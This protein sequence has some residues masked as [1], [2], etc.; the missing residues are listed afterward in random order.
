MK[1]AKVQIA[2]EKGGLR[3]ID[4][5]NPFNPREVNHFE[6]QGYTYGIALRGDYIYVSGWAGLFILKSYFGLKYEGYFRT[7]KEAYGVTVTGDY[8]LSN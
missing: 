3:V 6:L 1:L 7:P 5:S 4:V 2:N 8:A